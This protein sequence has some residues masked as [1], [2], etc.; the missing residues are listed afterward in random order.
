[1]KLKMTLSPKLKPN[2]NVPLVKRLVIMLVLAGVVFGGIFGFQAFK[3]HMIKQFMASNKAPP[4]T[5]SAVK[6]EMQ[7][8]QPQLSAVGSVRAVRGVDVTSEIAGMVRALHF[9]SGDRAQAGQLLVQLNADADVAQLHALEAAAELA[10]TTYE[11]DQAQFEIQAVSKAQLDA[12]AAD[13]KSKQAQ[14]AQQAAIVDKKAIHAPFAGRLGISSINP[15]QY[16]NPGDK[17]VTL[18]ELDPVY[19]DFSLPQQ[20]L[21][22]IKLG[23]KVFATTDTYPGQTFE[24]KITAIDPKVDPQTRNVQIEATQRNPKRQLLPGMFATVKVDS[25]ASERLLTLPQTAVTYN[26]Y[27]ET[28]YLVVPGGNG[29][30]GKP[31]LIVKQTF[32]T[33]GPT[34]GDQVAILKGVNEGDLVVT[35]GQLKLKNGSQVIIDNSV[36]PSNDAAPTPVDR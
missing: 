22:R 14:A 2:L 25:G 21:A 7:P 12:D 30:D 32:V 15:G 34:R 23:Q 11:R 36:Q 27:G 33:V 17:I 35:S 20:Q 31:I 24:G 1:M 9:K 13:L 6:A 29:P 19:V 3:A 10:R 28:L 18:Q 16:L 8:W 5:V 26:P 4:V